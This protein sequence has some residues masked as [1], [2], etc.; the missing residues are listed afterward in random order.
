MDVDRKLGIPLLAAA[1]DRLRIISSRSESVPFTRIIKRIGRRVAK[2]FLPQGIWSKASDIVEGQARSAPGIIKV[3]GTDDV[4]WNQHI[5]RWCWPETCAAV[6]R[7]ARR[8][9]P[10]AVMTEYALLSKCFAELSASTLKVIDT[11]EVFFRNR[12]RFELEG[13]TAPFVCSPE[14]EKEA[15]GRADLLIGIQQNETRALMELFPNKRVITVGHSYTQVGERVRIPSDGVV[16]YVGSSNPFNIHGLCQFL[17]HAWPQILS[18]LPLA[19][20]R[21]VGSCPPIEGV[22][23]QRVIYVGRVSDEDLRNEYRTA[24]VVINPQ[25][26]GTGLKIKCVEALTAGCAIVMNE[27]GADGLEEGAGRAFLLARGWPEFAQQVVQ[28]LTDDVLRRKLELEAIQLADRLFSMEA[29][30]AELGQALADATGHLPSG[31]P[32]GTG[33]SV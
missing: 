9:Q 30:F 22:D 16:L 27:T 26:A 32:S 23:G 20:L 8:L 13:L 18:Q 25:V 12:E 17:T 28:I 1:V 2:T 29:T 19:R 24:H 33:C 15:L 21:V 3:L 5:D 14:S 11:C 10:V 6:R 4:A 31:A 7:I